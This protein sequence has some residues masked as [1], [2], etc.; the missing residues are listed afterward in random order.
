MAITLGLVMIVK[1]ADHCIQKTLEAIKPHISYYGILDTGSTD[2]TVEIIRETM[3]GVNGM[4]YQEPFVDFSASRNRILDLVGEAVDYV[5]MLDDSYEL[6]NGHELVNFLQTDGQNSYHLSIYSTNSKEEYYSNRIFK[7]SAHIRYKY[8][9]HEIPDTE[10]AFFVPENVYIT[11]HVDARSLQ[12]SAERYERDIEL[13]KEHSDTNRRFMFHLAMTYYVRKSYKEA[14]ECFSRVA[15]DETQKDSF[16]YQS[17]YFGAMIRIKEFYEPTVNVIPI[18]KRMCELFPFLVEPFYRMAVLF[19]NEGAVNRAHLLLKHAITLP[20]PTRTF[21]TIQRELYEFE[22]KFLYILITFYAQDLNESKRMYNEMR[23]KYPDNLRL[24]NFTYMLYPETPLPKKMLL[25]EK[26]LIVINTSS[27]STWDPERIHATASGSEIM[28]SNIAKELAKLGNHVV[29]FGQLTQAGVFDG[30][31]Y[32][33]R[34][35]YA[36]YI[37]THVIQIFIAS[38]NVND[39]IFLPN[40]LKVYFWIHDVLPIGGDIILARRDRFGGFLCVSEWQK[41]RLIRDFAVSP[42]VIHVTRNAIYPERFVE[43][44]QKIPHRFMYHSSPER[45]LT[46]LLKLAPRIRAKYPDA[47]FEVFCG[48]HLVSREDLRIIESLEYVHLH[49]RVS[50][51]EVAQQLLATDV[52]LYPTDFDETYCISAVEAQ[53]AGCLCVTMNMGALKEIVNDRGVVIDGDIHL[54]EVQEKVLEKLFFVMDRPV[55][56]QRLTEKAIQWAS[57]QTFSDLA[58]E[59]NLLFTREEDI[60]M[61]RPDRE[62]KVV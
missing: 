54:P 21:F 7:T 57:R 23:E 38:R 59:W 52:W 50:Q 8:K 29:V 60:D 40:I 43:D 62:I 11:D 61:S 3:T 44:I 15:A 33:D 56:Q 9:I 20:I 31:E 17:M 2:K 39:L 53:M 58:V 10:D 19:Y 13:L 47:T 36:E 28:A 45:G 51:A 35:E 34:E 25:C 4:L 27:M 24:D 26:P 46:H 37:R 32:R 12:R 48:K 41:Q 14:Y 5:I 6:H 42:D 18:F 30:V 22:V 55:I 1:N 16:L 49:E